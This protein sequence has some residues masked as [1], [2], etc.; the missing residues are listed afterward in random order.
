MF[1]FLEKK[2]FVNVTKPSSSIVIYLFKKNSEMFAIFWERK[3]RKQKILLLED[4][5]F[6]ISSPVYPVPTVV[7][8]CPVFY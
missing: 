7:S 8:G 1:V 6:D 3:L 2:S 5:K 4:W